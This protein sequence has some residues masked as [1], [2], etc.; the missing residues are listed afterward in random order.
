MT[1]H[2]FADDYS[3]GKSQLSSIVIKIKCQQ[4][5]NS[6]NHYVRMFIYHMYYNNNNDDNTFNLYSVF[7]VTLNKEEQT[8]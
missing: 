3:G 5:I 1:N 4:L 8:K 7:Q 6:A 2:Y